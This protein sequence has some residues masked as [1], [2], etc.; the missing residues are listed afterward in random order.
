MDLEKYIG[1]KIRYYRESKNMN[2]EELAKK[3]NTTKQSISRYESGDRKTNQDILF[4][5]ADLFEVRLDDFFPN[6]DTDV[7]TP[8]ESTTQLVPIAG[9]I[10]AGS[11]NII[12]EDIEGY[13]TLPPD[14]KTAEGLMYLE[15]TS[16]SMSKKF[17]VGSYALIDTKQMV[18]NGDIAAI[19]INGDEAT[20]KKVKFDDDQ[21]IV[22]LIPQSHNPSY[23]S[24][25]IDLYEVEVQF[26]GKAIGM[27]SS[28]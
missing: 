1:N 21:R 12:L 18:E 10:A 7:S 15:V 25:D 20:L 24:V 2:Q 14:K 22:T 8:E 23:D 19:K 11:P 26:I 27:Y 13:M 6:R 28:F 5:L 9:K 17:P 16:D 3:L 4:K